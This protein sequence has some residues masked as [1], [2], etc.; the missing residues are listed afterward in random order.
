MSYLVAGGLLALGIMVGF[1]TGFAVGVSHV[2]GRS[3]SV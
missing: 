2:D 3:K 1:V